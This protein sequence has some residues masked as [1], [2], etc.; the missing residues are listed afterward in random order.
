MD[1]TVD[2]FRPLT[3][4]KDGFKVGIGG[5]DD[6]MEVKGLIECDDRDVRE[7]SYVLLGV[8]VSS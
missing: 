7:L 6:A 4:E 1:L 5:Q 2:A 8:L 3:M